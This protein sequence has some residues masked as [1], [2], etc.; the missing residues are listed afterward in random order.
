MEKVPYLRRI[1]RPLEASAYELCSLQN[2]Q[3][4]EITDEKIHKQP[5]E[6]KSIVTM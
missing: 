5:F 3:A 2:T 4:Q 6:R 1:H